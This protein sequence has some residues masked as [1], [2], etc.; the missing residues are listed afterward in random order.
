VRHQPGGTLTIGG[1]RYTLMLA[2]CALPDN[3]IAGDPGGYIRVGRSGTALVTFTRVESRRH[4]GITFADGRW[5]LGAAPEGSP[6]ALHGILDEPNFHYLRYEQ[7]ARQL[8]GPNFRKKLDAMPKAKRQAYEN[9][10]ELHVARTVPRWSWSV[11]LT[12]R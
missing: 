12:C 11:R 7:K 8:L 3:P 10:L 5:F 6:S 9:R 4:L 1:R 2:R